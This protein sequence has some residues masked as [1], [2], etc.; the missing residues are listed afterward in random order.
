[1]LPFAEILSFTGNLKPSVIV[2]LSFNKGIKILYIF[3]GFVAPLVIATLFGTALFIKSNFASR[4]SNSYNLAFGF[5]IGISSLIVLSRIL[6]LITTSY[7]LAVIA[8]IIFELLYVIYS[9][10]IISNYLMYYRLIFT[11][12]LC[13]TI[14]YLLTTLF[15]LRNLKDSH[16]PIGSVGTLHSYRYAW[17]SNLVTSCDYFPVLGQNTGQSSLS[18]ISNILSGYQ[19]PYLYLSLW[20]SISIFALYILIKEMLMSY[21]LKKSTSSLAAFIFFTLG[22]GLSITYVTIIDSGY[23]IY[24]NGYTDNMLG[25]GIFLI[26]INYMSK[27]LFSKLNLLDSIILVILLVNCFFVASQN[28]F[29]ILIFIFVF[30]TLYIIKVPSAAPN[31]FMKFLLFLIPALASVPLGGFFT[32]KGMLSR[33]EIPNV[34][35]TRVFKLDLLPGFPF[36]L[37]SPS[38]TVQESEKI[39]LN[40]KNLIDTKGISSS[41]T[42]WSIENFLLTN[43]RVLFFPL[44][45]IILVFALIAKSNR[46]ILKL[47]QN[48]NHMQAKLFFFAGTFSVII[49]LAIPTMLKISGYKWELTR[50][51][52][53]TVISGSLILSIIISKQVIERTKYQFLAWATYTISSI[54]PFIFFV[55]VCLEN[56]MRLNSKLDLNLYLSTGP[57]ILSTYCSLYR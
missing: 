21:G 19:A 34:D 45:G 32:P 5:F 7:R 6:S 18:A 10:T 57:V 54:G 37:T 12:I 28:L 29:A 11:N 33:I 40:L 25:I 23:P 15:W 46:T 2:T 13:V 36:N 51:A 31:L 43:F 24:L 9:R 42:I 1:M 52:L 50:L 16:Q 39:V 44:I 56:F 41:E 38:N 4:N 35:Q 30:I 27:K 8:L 22:S 48:L 14:I 3:T 53:P 47:S 17:I 20:L 26:I 55:T 49:L